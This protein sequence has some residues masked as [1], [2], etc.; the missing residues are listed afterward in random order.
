M[1]HQET[2]HELREKMRKRCQTDL[3]FL[4]KAILGFLD[5]TPGLHLPLC[6]YLQQD[7]YRRLML[8]PRGH[9]KSSMDTIGD[10]IRRVLNNRD[11]RILLVANT[12]TNAE[13]KLRRIQGEFQSNEILKWAFPDIIPVNFDKVKWT[14]TEMNVLRSKELEDCTIETIGVG[15]KV[16]S[17]HFDGIKCDDLIEKEAAESDEVMGSICRWY[18]TIEDLL[19]N[20]KSWIHLNGTRWTAKSSEIY[21]RIL[22]NK[23]F[24]EYDVVV[25]A[26]IEDED[27]KPSLSGKS[28][29]PERFPIDH[30][31][32][33]YRKDPYFF[34]CQQQ[35]NPI[36]PETTDFDPDW[37]RYYKVR[38]D[39]RFLLEHGDGS[40]SVYSREEL[41]ITAT[42][43]PA[44]G[45]EKKSSRSAIVVVGITPKSEKI[46]LE[47]WA[48]R[49]NPKL[50][51]EKMIQVQ[52]MWEPIEFGIEVVAFQKVFLHYYEEYRRRNPVYIRW[53]ELT[54]GSKMAK[55][56]RIMS[57]Q[58]YI[59]DGSLYIQE[60]M[61]DFIDEFTRF[62][63]GDTADIL[64]ALG[65]QIQLWRL[66]LSK[67]DELADKLAEEEFLKAIN[68][69]TGY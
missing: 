1:T 27:N 32:R 31:M 6:W 64:D 12:A 69:V 5:F 56:K 42:C 67:E 23:E 30:L 40:T 24:E 2:A 39:G 25:R 22:T 34:S 48:D 20:P 13:H 55:E 58:P 7:H 61:F 15:G 41:R 26:A 19:D 62:P 50:L 29:F 16:T 65:Y 9:F 10:T 63:L 51:L 37:L 66:P 60:G 18:L 17:R 47:A 11:I 53:L 45:M 57:I 49:V 43:D 68:Q 28:I 8:V 14:G 59:Q 35:N 44:I 33:K 4:C 52:Q 21:Y 36:N 46:V 3:F 54:P 38:P